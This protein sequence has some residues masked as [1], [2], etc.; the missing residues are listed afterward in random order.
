LRGSSVVG[1]FCVNVSML[2]I[3]VWSFSCVTV[4]QFR[5]HVSLF[6]ET[7]MRDRG[8]RGVFIGVRSFVGAARC[9]DLGLLLNHSLTIHLNVV[10]HVAHGDV[11]DRLV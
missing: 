8:V 11:L 6:R 5:L 1:G 2:G 7:S 10:V 9:L 4:G 3:V